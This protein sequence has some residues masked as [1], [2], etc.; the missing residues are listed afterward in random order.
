M[1]QSHDLGDVGVCH[2]ASARQLGIV[3]DG[4]AAHVHRVSPLMPA[5]ALRRANWSLRPKNI[6]GLANVAARSERHIEDENE[7]QAGEEKN[8][9]DTAGNVH[10]GIVLQHSLRRGEPSRP[11]HGRRAVSRQLAA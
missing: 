3:R 7:R 5:I 6:V 11:N 1:Q 10:G 8:Y 9:S 2:P 4:P